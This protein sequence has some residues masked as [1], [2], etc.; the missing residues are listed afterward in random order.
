MLVLIYYN[1]MVAIFKKEE[2]GYFL[3]IWIVAA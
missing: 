3:N 1:A 2:L